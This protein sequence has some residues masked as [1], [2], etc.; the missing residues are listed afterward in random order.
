VAQDL[1]DFEAKV[2]TARLGADGI[3]WELR[4]IVDSMYP[5]GGIDV[6]VPLDELEA[7][8]H[9]LVALTRD[10]PGERTALEGCAAEVAPVDPGGVAAARRGP[11]PES[12]RPGTS[13]TIGAGRRWWV[14]VAVIAG[15]VAFVAVRFVATVAWLQGDGRDHCSPRAAAEGFTARCRH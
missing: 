9:C 15:A 7:A 8:R 4:G 2:V 14:T 6:L 11:A 13:P 3:L 1:T 12:P 5:L 10:H